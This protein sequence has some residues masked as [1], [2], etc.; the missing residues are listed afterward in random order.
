M[1]EQ[2]EIVRR[3][4]SAFGWLDR[5]AADHAAAARLLPKLDAAILAK[6]FQRRIRP[7]GP[8]R[9]TRQRAA[10]TD[11][12]G[13]GGCT[14]NNTRSATYGNTTSA[15]KRQSE[16]TATGTLSDAA[17][18]IRSQIHDQKPPG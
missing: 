15:A 9:R 6:A 12:G 18:K 16:F 13:A 8:Q 10:G 5:M 17:Q 4:E 7:P 11:Q 3:I 2:A 1:E 14:E